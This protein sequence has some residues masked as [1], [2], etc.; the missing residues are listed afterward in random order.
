MIKNDYISA[1]ENFEYFL[2]RKR[3]HSKREKAIKM[4]QYCQFQIPYQQV[5]Y[6]V[7]AMFES[8]Y[9]EAIEWF[10]KAEIG[11]SVPIEPNAS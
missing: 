11:V 7:K 4:L 10:D 1:A 6:G 8:N 2:E 9:N 3:R 5:N